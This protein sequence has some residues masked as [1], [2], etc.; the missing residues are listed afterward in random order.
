MFDMTAHWPSS[1]TTYLVRCLDCFIPFT[2]AS[3]VILEGVLAGPDL[4]TC[5]IAQ[6]SLMNTLRSPDSLNILTINL[7]R[8]ETLEWHDRCGFALPPLFFFT[9][10]ERECQLVEGYQ[11]GMGGSVDQM[12]SRFTDS[13]V[14]E[15]DIEQD[16]A[17]P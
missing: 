14:I 2:S 8:M 17:H 7:S 1:S 16:I 4:N 11:I 3:L 15:Q 6:C 10:T 12:V 13:P 9:G 5:P